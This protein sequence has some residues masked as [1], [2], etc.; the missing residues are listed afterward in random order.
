M[1]RKRPNNSEMASMTL[2][3]MRGSLSRCTLGVDG[4]HEMRKV[5]NGFGRI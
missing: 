5:V 4:I 2:A 3:M 1:G